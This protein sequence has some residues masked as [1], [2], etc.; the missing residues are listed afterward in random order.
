M[1]SASERSE[2]N[3][4][5]SVPSLVAEM[6]YDGMHTV[7]CY[8]ASNA[9]LCENVQIRRSNMENVAIG[10]EMALDDKPAVF[11]TSLVKKKKNTN[12]NCVAAQRVE[13]GTHLVARLQAAF[14]HQF[15]PLQFKVEIGVFLLLLNVL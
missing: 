4:W 13:K 9:R 12:S 7:R 2:A 5:R 11:S 10:G 15:Y 6:G 14:L 8:S 3:R 1:P